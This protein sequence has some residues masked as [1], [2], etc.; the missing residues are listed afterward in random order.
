MS[1]YGFVALNLIFKIGNFQNCIFQNWILQIWICQK[2]YFQKNIAKQYHIDY[3][4][5]SQKFS[6]K[7]INI[8][9]GSAKDWIELSDH[10]PILC[11]IGI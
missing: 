3:F 2:L 4:F 8:N 10:M 9:V 5:G 6:E 11:E 7:L 1:K